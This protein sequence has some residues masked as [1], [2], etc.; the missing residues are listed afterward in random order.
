MFQF[1]D[2]FK[3]LGCVPVDNE[4]KCAR[5]LFGC[6]PV[7]DMHPKGYVLIEWL[8]SQAMFSLS[9]KMWTTLLGVFQFKYAFRWFRCVPMNTEGKCARHFYKYFQVGRM[10]S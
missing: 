7:L 5:H 8:C 4:S 2:V 3:K 6:F 9:E 10:C 1:R